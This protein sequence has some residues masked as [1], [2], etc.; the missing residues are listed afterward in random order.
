MNLL[1]PIIFKIFTLVVFLG[2]L[3]GCGSY[4]GEPEKISISGWKILYEQDADLETVSA[5]TGWK[6][7]HIPLSLKHPNPA[8][9]KYG[10]VWLKGECSINGNPRGYSGLTLGRVYHTVSLY[11]NG[12]EI[13]PSPPE[14]LTNIHMPKDYILPQGVLE[15]GKNAVYLRLGI[16]G[17]NYGGIYSEGYFYPKESFKD[18]HFLHY[19]FYGQL[20]IGLVILFLG[21]VILL[22]IFFLFNTKEKRYFYS[23][24]GLLFYTMGVL[25]IYAPYHRIGISHITSLLWTYISI[26]GILLALIIQSIYE[27]YLANFNKTVVPLLFLLGLVTFIM[28]EITPGLYQGSMLG[29]GALVTGTVSITYL[30]IRL[31]RLKKD[32]IRLIMV[33]MLSGVTLLI[34][35]AEL[36]SL[37]LGGRYKMLVVTYSS[38][39]IVLFFVIYYADNLMKKSIELDTL[40]SRLKIRVSDS[41][42]PSV[43][44][45]TEKKL[46]V[47]KHFINENYTSDLSREGLAAAVGMNPNYM[48]AQFK[49]YTGM[50]IG[51]YINF[52]RIEDAVKRLHD[53]DFRVLDIALSVGFESLSTF[54]RAFKNI[55]GKTPT[56]Y[57]NSLPGNPSDPA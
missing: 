49:T 54:N 34:S 28:S 4:P 14:Y 25:I 16:L 52:L 47:V 19:F 15:Q 31:N 29:F 32:K 5:K 43:S 46:E 44:E 40:Y 38:P 6:K 23:A 26:F 7:V 37:L 12:R 20:P 55:K 39:L 57:K 27:I 3:T 50:K 45:A 42:E 24:M 22:I 33:V 53:E 51:E 41:A 10:Y 2:L 9:K 48:S 56:E 21:L 11:I 8:A 1:K 18:L 17:D 35:C 13:S 36:L 30:V